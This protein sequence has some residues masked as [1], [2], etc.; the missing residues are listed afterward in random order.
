MNLPPFIDRDFVSPSQDVVRVETTRPVMLAA[1]GLFDPNEE[2]ALYF[3]WIGERS[4]LLE[5]AE[6]RPLPGNPRHREIFHVFDR[7][8]TELDPCSERLRDTD[9]ETIWLVVADRR[10]VR[11]TST[12]VEVAE[13]GFLVSHSWQLRFR[14]QLCA[15]AL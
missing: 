3:A 8:A 2:S 9:S 12:E 1:E 15:G 5:Q 6:V 13:G 10:F 11:V 14:P 7:V 4:G